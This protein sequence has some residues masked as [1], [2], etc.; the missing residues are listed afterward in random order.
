MVGFFF[1]LK[2]RLHLNIDRRI[3]YE[4]HSIFCKK[5]K[6]EDYKMNGVKL[7]KLIIEIE[8]SMGA[9]NAILLSGGYDSTLLFYI[10]AKQ[11][12]GVYKPRELYVMHVSAS[13]TCNKAARERKS[14]YDIIGYVKAKFPRIANR[15]HEYNINIDIG[16]L[17][18]NVC[19]LAQ[20]LF[21][22]PS[23]LVGLPDRDDMKIFFSY[24]GVDQ[25]TAMMTELQQIVNST[26]A[27]GKM[28][29][30]LPSLEF[31]FK[32]LMKPDIISLLIT[33][34]R[35]IFELCT[36][37]E[38]PFGVTDKKEPCGECVSCQDIKMA[39]IY[40]IADPGT[41]SEIK[42]FCKEFMKIEYAMD[43]NIERIKRSEWMKLRDNISIKKEEE[44]LD[45]LDSLSDD[46]PVDKEE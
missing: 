13:F 9:N 40:L 45:C 2:S 14:A 46:Q 11:M 4:S 33:L 10:L 29:F 5:I 18:H 24:I 6:R 36:T 3:L 38:D 23:L 37:C 22:L 27:V 1:Y 15:I 16:R 12:N 17:P 31:P 39:I 21:W 42:D 25:D 32:L 28:G 30:T 20:P 43:I 35:E 8:R 44:E 41:P 34:D 7:E 19:G 26:Y